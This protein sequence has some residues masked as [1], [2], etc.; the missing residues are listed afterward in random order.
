M[1]LPNKLYLT[2]PHTTKN[3]SAFVLLEL[4][5]N[6]NIQ[7]F[8]SKNEKDTISELTL[9]AEP[10]DKDGEYTLYRLPRYVAFI[11]TSDIIEI[12]GYDLTE[13]KDIS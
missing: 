7:I 9:Q 2:K 3:I 12:E 10:F 11:G 6:V 1:I 8:G 5:G 13:I 4:K